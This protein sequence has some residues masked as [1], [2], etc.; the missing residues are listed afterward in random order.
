LG[1]LSAIPEAH[2]YLMFEGRRLD[3]TGLTGGVASPFDSLIEER[4]FSEWDLPSQKILYHRQVI[5]AWARDRG[6][7][8]EIVWKKRENCIALLAK[9]TRL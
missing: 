3:F 8:P 9:S 1:E 2:C 7:N 4:V 6:L 5:D